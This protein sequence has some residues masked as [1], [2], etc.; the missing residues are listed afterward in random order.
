MLRRQRLDPRQ[1]QNGTEEKNA[2]EPRRT[3]KFGPAIGRA[4]IVNEQALFKIGGHTPPPETKK[5]EHIGYQCD[6]DD[7]GCHA[8]P[9]VTH[10]FPNGT[11]WACLQNEE[12]YRTA[13]KP[14]PV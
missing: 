12:K 7:Q 3:D 8:Q 10:K 6:D 14:F 13:K 5:M 2:T 11:I 4:R 1:I 9:F